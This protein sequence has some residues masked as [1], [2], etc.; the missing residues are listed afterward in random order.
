MDI[1]RL[2]KSLK[3]NVSHKYIKISF[4]ASERERIRPLEA[5][6][7]RP[8]YYKRVIKPSTIPEGGVVYPYASKKKVYVEQY[9]KEVTPTTKTTY[10]GQKVP[11]V[12]EQQYESEKETSEVAP[13]PKP[14]VR[15]VDQPEQ[16]E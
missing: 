5:Y 12:T 6:E 4:F 3:I 9:L 14:P 13:S 10:G 8:L 1:S 15:Y 7:S 2:Y 11:Q 16:Q